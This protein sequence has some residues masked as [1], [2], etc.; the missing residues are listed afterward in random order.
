[1]HHLINNDIDINDEIDEIDRTHS[2]NNNGGNKSRILG[3]TP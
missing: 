3:Q 2:T 1:M